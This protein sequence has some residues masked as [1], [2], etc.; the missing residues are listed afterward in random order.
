MEKN[1][2]LCLEVLRS[3]Q[4]AGV[5][6]DLILVGSWC[7]PFYR[8]YFSSTSYHPSIRT[9][10]IDFLVPRPDR[11][12]K[13]VDLAV[14]LKEKGFVQDYGNSGFI[15]FMHPELIVSRVS[16]AGQGTGQR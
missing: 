12:K 9:R 2:A 16:R 14:L 4:G 11:F 7:L 3:F 13:K 5:L 10:D 15:R 8:D 1:Y 6:S